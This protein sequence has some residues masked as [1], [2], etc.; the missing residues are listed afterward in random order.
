[1]AQVLVSVAVEHHRYGNSIL[2]FCPL[3]FVCDILVLNFKSIILCT[4]FSK[5]ISN[6]SF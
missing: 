3:L 1:M 4:D 2:F 5:T 6:V